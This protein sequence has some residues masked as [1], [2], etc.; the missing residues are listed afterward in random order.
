MKTLQYLEILGKDF[1]LNNKNLFL[2]YQL[3]GTLIIETFDEVLF[4]RAI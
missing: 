3:T 2:R 1:Q 4:Y